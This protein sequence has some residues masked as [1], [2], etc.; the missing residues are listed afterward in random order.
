MKVHAVH[1][2]VE[3]CKFYWTK[4]ALGSKKH[5]DASF[6]RRDGYNRYNLAVEAVSKIKNL[7]HTLIGKGGASSEVNILDERLHG[8]RKIVDN[9]GPSKLREIYEASFAFIFSSNYKGYGLTSIACVVLVMY[10]SIS[11]LPVV[12]PC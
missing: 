7:S 8:L 6:G 3:Q 9:V 12:A 1:L 11:S 10:S 4:K 5:Y 2:G